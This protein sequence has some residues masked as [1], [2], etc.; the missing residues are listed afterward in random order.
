MKYIIFAGLLLFLANCAVQSQEPLHMDNAIHT[1]ENTNWQATAINNGRGAI[2]PSQGSRSITARFA[3]GSIQ[4][5]GGCNQ[6]SA[7]YTRNSGQ[8]HIAQLRSTQR[9][10]A[11]ASLMEQEAY[12]LKALT[13]VSQ[14]Q[15]SSG[16]LKLLDNNGLVMVEFAK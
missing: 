8:L 13:R 6:F 15:L 14:Y 16:Q 9:A 12:F 2:V 4:G 1:L 7:T 3:N 5:N 10:C 11:E